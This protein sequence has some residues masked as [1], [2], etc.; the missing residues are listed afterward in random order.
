MGIEWLNSTWRSEGTGPGELVVRVLRPCVAKDP[1]RLSD[2]AALR[3]WC[4][5]R[6]VLRSHYEFPS[7]IIPQRPKINRSIWPVP[8]GI[9][10]ALPSCLV[11][12]HPVFGI[13]HPVQ[14]QAIAPF[15]GASSNPSLTRYVE[16]V[17]HEGDLEIFRMLSALVILPAALTLSVSCN[18]NT[19]PDAAHFLR[20]CR[21]WLS[22]HCDSFRTPAESTV[23]SATVQKAC[24]T[25]TESCLTL[26]TAIEGDAVRQ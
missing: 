5:S 25:A 3:P 15:D 23:A 17:E 14:S 4:C 26:G 18:R 13:E 24:D 1:V 20:S 2:D 16:H 6:T 7:D 9:A 19:G 21:R 8:P 11:P 10:I 12:S 22:V